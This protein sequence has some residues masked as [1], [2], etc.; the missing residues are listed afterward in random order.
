MAVRELCTKVIKV[1]AYIAQGE[2]LGN[3]ITQIIDQYENSIPQMVANG[4]NEGV[5]TPSRNSSL[6]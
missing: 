5:P 4:V 2:K 6:K 3:Q 1:S